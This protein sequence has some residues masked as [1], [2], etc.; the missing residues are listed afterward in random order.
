MEDLETSDEYKPKLTSK[1]IEKKLLNHFTFLK[2]ESNQ[3]KFYSEFNIDDEDKMIINI[4]ENIINY[5]YEEIFHC[6]S[7]SI[8]NLKQSIQ[9][10]NKFP[11][12]FE[13]IIQYLVY[14]K[15]YILKEDLKNEKFYTY[16]FPHLFQKY[17]YF[18]NIYNYLPFFD[19]CKTED[20]QNDEN[21]LEEETKIRNDLNK[22]YLSLIIP[23]NSIIINY[24]IFKHHC[25]AI[26][27]TLKD[28]LHEKGNDIII[29]ND[30]IDIISKEY[31]NPNL[32]NGKFKLAYGLQLIEEA[33][34]YLSHIKQIIIF[35]I[36]ES[37]DI[38]FIKTSKNNDDIEKEEDIKT[39]KKLF[40]E[41]KNNSKF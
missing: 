31:I 11:L 41:F 10:K 20:N 29:K 5:I 21:D 14:N 1:E 25:D 24:K 22:N 28:I 40:E 2:D 3:N 37:K 26:L 35:K 27:I 16:N 39:A 4:W 32:D 38:E 36:K 7:L 15:K 9:I 23:D 30:F 18:S 33:I 34:F 6:M 19:F 8:I 13:L 17:S 12:N